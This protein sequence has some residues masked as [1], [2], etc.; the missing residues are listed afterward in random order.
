LDEIAVSPSVDPWSYSLWSINPGFDQGAG[1]FNLSLNFLNASAYNQTGNGDYPIPLAL[2]F[3]AGASLL[4][5]SMDI[6]GGPR[7]LGV[8]AGGR[9]SLLSAKGNVDA[10]WFNGEAGRRGLLIDANAGAYVAEGEYYRGLT[11]GGITVKTV[12]GGSVLSAHAGITGGIHY[13]QSSG[14]FTIEGFEHVGLGIGEKAGF[15][16]E[17]PIRAF[18]EG[19]IGF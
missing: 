14:I 5:G 16:I 1:A 2:S 9:G 11:L 12:I 10:G 3:G 18:K 7:A 15:K 13:N 8:L 6:R 4:E 19:K 17:I